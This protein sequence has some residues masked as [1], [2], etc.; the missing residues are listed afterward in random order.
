MLRRGAYRLASVL[1]HEAH[2][3]ALRLKYEVLKLAFVLK[4]EVTKARVLM[5]KRDSE[6][7]ISKNSMTITFRREYEIHV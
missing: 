6:V 3:L 2:R 4:R 1:E 7:C 5:L